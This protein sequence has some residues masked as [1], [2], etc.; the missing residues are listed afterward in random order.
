MSVT[1]TLT[2]GDVLAE[3]LV[4]NDIQTIFGLPGV[5]LDGAFDALARRR[6]RVRLYHTRHEQ[7]T[8]YMASG[9]A[10]ATG[11]IGT[12]LVVPGPGLLNAMA[13]L[14]T[15]YACSA[16]VLCLT[17]Q[18]ATRDIGRGFG[19]LH[20]I[21]HQLE[22]L[23]SVTKWAARAN[24]PTEVG[25]TIAEAFRQLGLGRPAP[26]AVEI[27]PDV[28]ESEALGPVR[29]E[30]GPSPQPAPPALDRAVA[31]LRRA[32]RPLIVTGGG[33]LR[34]AAWDPL[35][36]LAERLGAP[37]L[38]TQN[39]LGGLDIDHPLA[40]PPLAGR[41]LLEAADVILAVGTRFAGAEEGR[42]S[43]RDDQRL[44]RIDVAAEELRRGVE[45]TV[46]VETDARVA[47]NVLVRA[48]DPVA[49]ATGW[50]E[51]AP[52]KD[53][54]LQVAERIQPLAAYGAAV[55]SAL[56]AETIVVAGMTQVGYWCRY[57]FPV[58]LPRTYLTSGYQGTL[59]FEYPTG[60]GAQVGRPDARTVVLV[61]D[62]GFLF[63]VQELATAVQHRI[64]AIAVVF[65]D[66]A[67]GNVKRIQEERFEGRVIGSELQ[68]PDLM[69][70]A[71]A[72]GLRGIRARSP[73][74]LERGLREALDE[75]GPV[76]VEVPM[77]AVPDPWSF[78]RGF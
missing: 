5:Q 71:A 68:N 58:H 56:P 28:L 75:D 3:A 8:S 42:R 26:V 43:Y 72:F 60:L 17:G 19:R 34:A 1:T 12:C 14:S 11:R 76:L 13:G 52:L 64:P 48:L 62:G 45:P 15:A 30:R 6:D 2:G 18:I 29:I 23:R 66:G 40:F 70:L 55:R 65:N 51:L 44:V 61:G 25:T 32:E 63:N 54:V 38:L 53:E 7:A 27:P 50:R 69:Q 77:P 36:E 21:P 33:V 59:G 41:R 46:A 9:F 78:T 35:R 10:L 24:R 4:A 47:L 39:G 31:L 57:G 74:A 37:V 73:E 20:E 16:P 22:A 67:Y 49:R